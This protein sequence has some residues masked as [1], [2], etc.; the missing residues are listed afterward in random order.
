MEIFTPCA[1][2]RRLHPH[3]RAA[4]ARGGK[5]RQEQVRASE[6]HLGRD[7]ATSPVG[8]PL[9]PAVLFIGERLREPRGSAEVVNQ[10][11]VRVKPIHTPGIKHH[12]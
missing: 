7:A 4:K 10:L 8:N 3:L 5:V 12:V 11:V 6:L 2:L 1:H 9:R